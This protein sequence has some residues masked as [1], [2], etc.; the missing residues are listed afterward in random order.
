[1]PFTQGHAL[2]IGVGTYQYEPKMNVPVTAADAQAVA[3]VLRDPAFCGYPDPQVKP[4]RNSAASRE[5][6]LG[7]LDALAARAGEGDTVFLFF[8]GHGDYGDDG[9]YY[10][11]TH[12]TRLNNRKVVSGT[13][14]RQSEFIEKLR[15]IKAKRLLLV[16]NACHAGELAPTLGEGEAPYTGTPLPAQTAAALLS[17][18]EGRII[19]TACREEQRSYIG[20]RSLT[21][22]THALV[23]AL[24]GRGTSSSRGY[25]S[26][27]DLYTHLYF[28]VEEAVRQKYSATQEP[29]LTVLKGV[30]PFAVSLYRGATTLGEFDGSGSAPERMAVREVPPAYAQTMLRQIVV[31]TG[32]GAI[33]GGNVQAG[34]HVVGRDMKIVHGDQITAGDISGAGIA[35][36]RGAQANVTQGVAPRDLES[37]F[38]PLLA[39][40][41]QEAPVD[42]KTAAAQQ[43]QELKAEIAKGTQADDGKI[44]STVEGLAG[45]A[46][47]AVGTIVG[48]FAN[49]ILSGVAGPITKYVLEK[50]IRS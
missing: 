15:A 39:A 28:T 32:G 8:C 11:T 40:I 26:A 30:G 23:D 27:F 22:F 50:L 13:G 33:F 36:G 10:L 37:L 24:Q 12:D 17:T 20:S 6:I 7:A 9:G 35:I 41:A 43:V 45:L 14:L 49:P 42:K 18:G 48:I 19:I 21:L 2:L 29:E 31:N 16:V 47:K 34:G 25:L 3:D 4:L 44:A 5:S 38:A 1:M 46:P